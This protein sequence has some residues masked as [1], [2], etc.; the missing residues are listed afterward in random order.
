MLSGALRTQ[1]KR[2]VNVQDNAAAF[3]NDVP[4][5]KRCSSDCALRQSSTI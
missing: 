4:A 3:E 5:S 2:F 1:K